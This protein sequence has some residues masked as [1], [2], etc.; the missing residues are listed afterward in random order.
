[1]VHV[2]SECRARACCA[3]RVLW[4]ARPA[5]TPLLGRLITTRPSEGSGGLLAPSLLRL[6]RPGGAQ[7]ARFFDDVARFPPG[8]AERADDG[9]PSVGGRSREDQAVALQRRIALRAMP[10]ALLDNLEAGVR[11]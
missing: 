7:D 4:L 5:D 8:Q 6:E 11:P 3:L 2:L 1:M 9:V 10:A